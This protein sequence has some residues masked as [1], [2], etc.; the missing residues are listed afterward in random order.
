MIKL[1]N[2]I[3]LKMNFKLFKLLLNK[4]KNEHEKYNL[5]YQYKI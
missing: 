5:D 1:S 2:L 4:R 3:T